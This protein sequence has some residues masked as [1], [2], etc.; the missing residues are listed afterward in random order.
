MDGEAGEFF[1]DPQAEVADLSGQVLNGGVS[2]MKLVPASESVTS[3]VFFVSR[4]FL[5]S[6]CSY[7]S[8]RI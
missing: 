5:A 6:F 1:G 3:Q 4:R 7:Y 2:G 8:S